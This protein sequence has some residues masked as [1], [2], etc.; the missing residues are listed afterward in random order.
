MIWLY[1]AMVAFGILLH[2][3]A[4]KGGEKK[5]TWRGVEVQSEW[6]A[7]VNFAG[8]LFWLFGLGL[9]IYETGRIYW[10]W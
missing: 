5:V 9:A 1:I 10:G 7:P 3:S 6:M 8:V 2:V 4:H